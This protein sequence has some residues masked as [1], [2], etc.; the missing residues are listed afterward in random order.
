M[1]LVPCWHH[2]HKRTP[3]PAISHRHNWQLGITE[4][5]KCTLNKMQEKWC[6]QIMCWCL[7]SP[8]L[9]TP[10]NDHLHCSS[11]EQSVFC[12]CVKT[13]IADKGLILPSYMSHVIVKTQQHF[14]G[15]SRTSVPAVS[16]C[17]IRESPCIVPIFL[18]LSPLVC[19]TLKQI[20][21]CLILTASCWNTL[22]DNE[23]KT[24][25]GIC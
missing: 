11:S 23:K 1:L 7:L 5:F 10:W 9:K 12:V 3:A 20:W 22:S 2:S 18:C 13:A 15:L 8:A 19:H 14:T 16:Y 6:F 17:Q 4:I 21:F 25:K 24:H